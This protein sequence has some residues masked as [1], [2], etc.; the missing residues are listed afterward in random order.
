MFLREFTAK[1]ILCRRIRLYGILIRW[2]S[3]TLLSERHTRIFRG[4][5]SHRAIL[6]KH[7]RFKNLFLGLSRARYLAKQRSFLNLGRIILL[8]RL[9]QNSPSSRALQTSGVWLKNLRRSQS[10]FLRKENK[11]EYNIRLWM[12]ICWIIQIG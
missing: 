2:R 12:V 1:V 5:C 11:F 10:I 8:Q 4:G 9:A 3:T 6:A 7:I